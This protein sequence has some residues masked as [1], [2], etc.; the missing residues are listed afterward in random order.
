[1]YVNAPYAVIQR[2]MHMHPTVTELHDLP[3]VQSS[4]VTAAAYTNENS[5]RMKSNAC[6]VSARLC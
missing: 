6:I 1:M 3:A 5:T 4:C 2:A